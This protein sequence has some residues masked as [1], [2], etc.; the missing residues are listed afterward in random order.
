M[1]FPIGRGIE[2]RESLRLENAEHLVEGE[3]KELGVLKAR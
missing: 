1:R 2:I 3:P